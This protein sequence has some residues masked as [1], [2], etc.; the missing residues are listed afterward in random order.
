MRL[1]REPR[2]ETPHSGIDLQKFERATSQGE[3]EN[4]KSLEK[5]TIGVHYLRP[6]KNPVLLLDRI[7]PWF[8]RMKELHREKSSLVRPVPA[9]VKLAEQRPAGYDEQLTNNRDY[10]RDLTSVLPMGKD[11]LQKTM[12]AFVIDFTM[13]ATSNMHPHAINLALRGP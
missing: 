8:E 7:P 3:S 5:A 12:I 9:K 1:Q 13:E 2:S 10:G 4:V 11:V 6:T